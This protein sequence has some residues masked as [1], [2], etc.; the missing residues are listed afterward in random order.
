MKTSYKEQLSEH[1][2][3]IFKG[4]TESGLHICDIATGG[5]KSYTIGKLTCEYYPQ[6]FDRIIILCVQTKLVDSMKKEIDKFLNKERSH[7]KDDDVLIVQNNR[8]VI[9]AAFE[10]KTLDSLIEEIAHVNGEEENKENKELWQKYGSIKKNREA[11]WGL[12]EVSKTTPIENLQKTIE[13]YEANLR[14]SISQYFNAFKHH[15]KQ[16]EHIKDVKLKDIERR[17]PSLSKVYPQVKYKSKRVLLMTVHKA[18]YGIDPILTEKVGLTDLAKGKTLLLLDES[19]Q[20]AVAMRN[21]LIDQSIDNGIGAKRYMS[22]YDGYLQWK[23]LL[24]KKD[25][26]SNN[27][28]VNIEQTIDKSIKITDSNWKKKMGDVLTYPNIFLEENED[29]E[30]YRKGVFF[31]G[32]I[33]KLSISNKKEEH[34]TS[35]ICHKE[36]ERNLRL[37]HSKEEIELNK[38]HQ[39]IRLE[40]FLNLSISNVT[41]IKSQ[42]RQIVVDKLEQQR[43]EVKR[44]RDEIANNINQ[45]DTYLGDPTLEST[46]HTLLS[47]FERSDENL[48]KQQLQNFITNRKNVSLKIEDKEFKLPDYSVYSQGIK[49]FLEE[50]DEQDDEHRIR[51]FCR[52]IDTTPEKIL[53]DITNNDKASVVLCS[54]TSSCTSVVSNF[55]IEYLKQIQGSRVKNLS[56]A[57]RNK[58]DELVAKTY[59]EGHNISIQ[60]IQKYIETEKRQNH[61]EVPEKY[62][63]MFSKEAQEEGLHNLWLKLTLKD[64]KKTENLGFELNRY[65]QFIEVYRWFI[66]HKD[67]HSM[68]Y[69]QNKRGDK[70]EHQFQCLSCLIDGT[71]KNMSEIDDKIPT[72]WKNDN[73]KITNN[74]DQLEN[75]IL[76]KLSTDKDAKIMLIAAYGSF[77]AGTNMQY[78]IPENYDNCLM[79]DNWETDAP[80]QKDWDA[81][82]LQSPTNYVSMYGDTT[83]QTFEKALYNVMLNLAMLKERGCLSSNEMKRALGAALS[84]TFMF[85]KNYEGIRGDKAAWAQT[86]IEQSVGRLCRTRNKP[87]TTYILHDEE[88]K[89]YILEKNLDKSLTAEFK[90]LA[91][92]IIKSKESDESKDDNSEDIVRCNNA[93]YSQKILDSIRRNA[94]RYSVHKEGY[95]DDDDEEENENN[96]G[97]AYAVEV[98]QIQNQNYKQIIIKHPVINSLEELGEEGRKLTFISK[99]YGD[100][101][102]NEDKG[103]SFYYNDQSKNSTIIPSGEKKIDISPKKAKLEVLMKNEVIKTHFEKYGYATDWKEGSLILHPK[104]LASDYVGEIGEEA[105]R[106]I[107][108]KYTDIKENQLTHL[109]GKDYELADFIIKNPDGTNRIAIDVKN[110]RPRADHDDREGDIH[111]S[112]KRKKKEERL[113]CNLITVNILKLENPTH[114]DK[115]IGGLIDNEGNIVPEGIEKLNDLLSAK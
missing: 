58:F 48:F 73:L 12:F 29:M 28:F 66:D 95:E 62:A 112:E 49:L 65:Y 106:A 56:D 53:I 38:Y 113:K 69:F 79:G 20:A 33:N 93:N 21:C 100:W 101:K 74:L 26:L 11:L 83:E 19:D 111:T 63:K 44:R 25:L 61:I 39:K 57:D 30:E 16:T 84:N 70:D 81:M 110:M 67:V 54:A 90:K 72:D 43:E 80:K 7:I 78:A 46:I 96:S 14:K 77:K 34:S 55:D 17:F 76:K 97:V 88:L 102:R 13:E 52:E 24:Q 75:D 109:E 85:G 40:D 1:V 104:I 86:M 6:Y 42:L 10:N 9:K 8:E 99:C 114:S 18:M 51:L 5:G 32:P 94:L 45:K 103:Y 3:K 59:P 50:L 115:E 27:H 41:A 36:G 92:E 108:F 2:E 105:F 91:E 89:E 82:F 60:Q 15:I 98:A 23:D 37:V 35:Y 71:Y 68:I 64:I 4:Y 47:R 22:G 31:S 87:K 107:V